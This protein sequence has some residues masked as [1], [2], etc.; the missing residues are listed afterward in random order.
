[1]PRPPSAQPPGAWKS[2]IELL[3]LQVLNIV[4]RFVQELVSAESSRLLGRKDA[5][6]VK[7]HIQRGDYTS[8]IAPKLVFFPIRIAD[9]LIGVL[10]LIYWVEKFNNLSDV[11]NDWRVVIFIT[12]V[13]I[14]ALK[15]LHWAWVLSRERFTW[16]MAFFP[17]NNVLDWMWVY[18]LSKALNSNLQINTWVT[19]GAMLFVIGSS[20]ELISE[21]QRSRFKRDSNNEGKLYTGGLFSVVIH[22]NYMGYILWRSAL[23]LMTGYP[24]LFGISLVFHFAQFYFHADPPFQKYM[25]NKYGQAWESYVADHRKIIPGIV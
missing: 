12:C 15:Q 13:L 10:L 25:S 20:I 3:N 16:F 24:V 9:P 17:W 23:S 1:V 22:P 5:T 21:L 19:I 18:F 6:M 14:A 7:D 11:F 2:E 4:G 8:K